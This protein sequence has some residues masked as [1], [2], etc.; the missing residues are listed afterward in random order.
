VVGCRFVVCRKLSEAPHDA[1][2]LVVRIDL[3][4]PY[5]TS[6]GENG[7]RPQGLLYLRKI[8]LK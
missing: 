8:T 1:L 4:W 7:S 3:N 5:I 6:L 2:L